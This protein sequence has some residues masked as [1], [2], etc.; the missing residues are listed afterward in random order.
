MDVL[1]DHIMNIS[2]DRAIDAG[3]NVIGF[4]AAGALMM[5]VSSMF[6]RNRRTGT[7][8]EVAAMPTEAP[9]AAPKEAESPEEHS[10]SS[11]SFVSFGDQPKRPE[12]TAIDRT[13]KANV[14]GGRRNRAEVIRLAREMIEA[15]QSGEEIRK[16]LPITEAE[17]AMLDTDK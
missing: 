3:L 10:R 16:R 6:Q 11:V 17:L 4:L 8:D 14:S 15:R 9:A 1:L 12:T 13:P 2:L 7:I 5:V